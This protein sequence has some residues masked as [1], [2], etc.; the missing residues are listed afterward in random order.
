MSF[1]F[2]SKLGS[3][4]LFPIEVRVTA[5]FLGVYFMMMKYPSELNVVASTQ[6]KRMVLEVEH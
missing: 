1:Y 5:L 4:L 3:Y 6:T 2:H